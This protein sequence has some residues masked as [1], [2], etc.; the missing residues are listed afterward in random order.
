MA[1]TRGYSTVDAPA[2]LPVVAIVGRP[3]VGKST[4]FNRI[5]GRRLAIVA[6]EP[7]VTRDRQFA[8][9][10]WAGRSFMLVDTGGLV[11]DADQPMDEEI[12]RQVVMAIERAD[13]VIHVV[14][15]RTGVHPVDEHV[16]EL[17]RRSGRPVVLAVNKVDDPPDDF[18]HLD[19]YRLGLG[20]PTP[21]SAL[22]GKGSGDLLDRLVGQLPDEEEAG[23]APAADLHLAVIGKPNVGKSSFVNR[24]LGEERVVVHS[25][26]G[27]TRDAID[28][29]LEFEG[30]TVCLIDTAGL[31]RQSRV[32]DDVEFY[33]RLRAAAAIRR[34][35][36]CLLLV[37]SAQGATNQ[38]FRIGENAWQ[39]GCGLVFVANKWDLVE[40]RGPDVVARFAEA[41]RERAA[42]L[43]RVP[44]VTASALTGQRV[45]K[46][47]ELALEVQ[48][49]RRRRIPTSEVNEVLEELLAH[50][51]P[52]QGRS[53][54]VRIYYATQAAVEPPLFVLFA[55]RPSELA[56]HYV[57]Y[58]E[59]R[60][61]ERWNFEGTPIRMKV[62]KRG[63]GGR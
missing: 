23:E 47:L 10:D 38:D 18:S 50:R 52:P 19:F 7:G 57:R 12:R 58:L 46:G 4:L 30:H 27:T 61:R 34:A 26:A 29:Y 53:G 25:E 22:S 37:D 31:R 14:D 45:R 9:A 28:T 44:I 6:E 32:D 54:D 1:V 51:Q 60:F 17:L 35:D 5:L 24:L 8:A 33:S 39:E 49:N 48:E 15:A 59:N 20:D 36:V 3:N 2:R 42:Y 11:H 62:K 21:V 55:N 56:G 63:S 13:V 41:L 16:A 43:R 40:D